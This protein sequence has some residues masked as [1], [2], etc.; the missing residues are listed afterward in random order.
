LGDQA[1][2]QAMPE[3]VNATFPLDWRFLSLF[4]RDYPRIDIAHVAVLSSEH[5]VEERLGAMTVSHVCWCSVGRFSI[6]QSFHG[7][8][9]GRSWDHD[10]EGP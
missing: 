9:F 6:G 2:A 4:K 7:I 5:R 3:G 10:R 1:F 8:S